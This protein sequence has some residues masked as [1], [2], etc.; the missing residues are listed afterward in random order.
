MKIYIADL[1]D[2]PTDVSCDIHAFVRDTNA[3]SPPSI[4]AVC[5]ITNVK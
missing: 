3:K 5:E 4:C 2:L 1:A